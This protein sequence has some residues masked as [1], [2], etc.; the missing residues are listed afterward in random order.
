MFPLLSSHQ[1]YQIF[2]THTCHTYADM[3]TSCTYRPQS[4]HPKDLKVY[5]LNTYLP[6]HIHTYTKCIY[7]TQIYII[8]DTENFLKTPQIQVWS[9]SPHPP[10]LNI[11][12]YNQRSSDTWTNLLELKIKTKA[13]IL[14]NRGAGGESGRTPKKRYS[15]RNR[16]QFQTHNPK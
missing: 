7:K 16:P 1:Y 3:L 10:L 12:L 5:V 4:T 2:L 14:C 15:L 6:T 13:N 11:W 8:P 9:T